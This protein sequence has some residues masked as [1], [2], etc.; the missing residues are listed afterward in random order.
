MY[1]ENPLANTAASTNVAFPPLTPRAASD[2]IAF[3]WRTFLEMRLR[4]LQT[5]LNW[6]REQLG[7]NP[8]RCP[9][10]GELIK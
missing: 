10:C 7:Y 6:I 1:P 9:H 5:E 2:T 3:N 8:K 4:V